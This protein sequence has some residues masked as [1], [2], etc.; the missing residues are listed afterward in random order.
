MQHGVIPGLVPFDGKLR[1]GVIRPKLE[2]NGEY[3]HE[4][5]CRIG[6]IAEQTA[7]CII[8][9]HEKPLWRG[10]CTST[11]EAIAAVVKARAPHVERIG[12]ESG[13]LSTWHWHELTKL[14]LPVICLDARHAKAAL[15]PG[16]QDRS[17]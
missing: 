10:K 16:E 3:P 4:A 17:Q 13:P 7:V 14:G 15:S 6:W 11:P 8:D 9:E 12:L 2:A 5:V 1:S